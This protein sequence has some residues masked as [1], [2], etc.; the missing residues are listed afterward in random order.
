M[1]LCLNISCPFVFFHLAPARTPNIP[2]QFNNTLSF[3]S[4][5]PY[6]P[7][8]T[9]AITPSLSVLFSARFSL[10]ARHP[11]QVALSPRNISNLLCLLRLQYC[12]FS[13]SS[14]TISPHAIPCVL[15]C[16]CSSPMTFFDTALTHL[17]V[18]CSYLIYVIYILLPSLWV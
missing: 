2:P 8:D 7:H 5:Y 11:L 18:T 13:T 14:V 15:V 16:K 9:F 3:H 1:F 4:S 17:A 6:F 12:F 10:W